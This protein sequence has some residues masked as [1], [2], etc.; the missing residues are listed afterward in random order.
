[1]AVQAA[2]IAPL[3]AVLAR[4]IISKYFTPVYVRLLYPC[5]E[6]LKVLISFL[7]LFAALLAGLL[8]IALNYQ[9]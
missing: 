6:K 1:M 4:L 5:C 8:Q 9:V 3:L 7:Y 2:A